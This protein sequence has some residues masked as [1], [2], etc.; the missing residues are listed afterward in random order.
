V[1]R[2]APDLKFEPIVGAGEVAN[3]KPAPDGLLHIGD[4]SWSRV[5]D[6]ATELSVGDVM[7]LK[8]LKWETKEKKEPYLVP[9]GVAAD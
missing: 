1:R 6:P 7:D 9:S 2:F 4:I 8:I 5:T 3:H